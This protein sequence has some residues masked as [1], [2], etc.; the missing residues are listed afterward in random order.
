M[1]PIIPK[2][3]MKQSPLL[4]EI[5]VQ[6]CAIFLSPNKRRCVWIELRYSV[7]KLQ[8]MMNFA[9]SEK[10]GPNIAVKNR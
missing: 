9:A 4:H 6:G 3:M 1:L 5:S 7:F 8:K 10:K 2:N